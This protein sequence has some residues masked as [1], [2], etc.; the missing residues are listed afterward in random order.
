MNFTSHGEI[1]FENDIAPYISYGL[2]I[3]LLIT[4]IVSEY[5]SIS[6]CSKSNGMVDA[7]VKSLAEKR[8]LKLTKSKRHIEMAIV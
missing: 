3:I 2:N 6:K 5:L 8:E 7:V 4:T 1:K